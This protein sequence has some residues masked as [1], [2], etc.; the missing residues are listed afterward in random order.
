[1]KQLLQTINRFFEPVYTKKRYYIH[2]LF[3]VLARPFYGIIT[4]LFLAKAV[5][6]IQNPDKDAFFLIVGIYAIF[7]VLYQIYNY[8]G[9]NSGGWFIRESFKN[10]YPKYFSRFIKMDGNSFEKVGTGKMSSIITKGIDTRQ[11]LLM[12]T[13]YLGICAIVELLFVTYL[14][15]K[16]TRYSPLILY[17]F[18]IVIIII[19]AQLARKANSRREKR[20]DM[21]DELSRQ[22]TKIIMSKIDILLNNKINL[23]N[24]KYIN[25]LDEAKNYDTRKQVYEHIGFNVPT[26]CIALITV[27]LF[28]VLGYKFFFEQA[29]SYADIVLY[30]GLINSLENGTRDA[31][32]L[33]KTFSKNFQRVTKLWDIF[34]TIPEIK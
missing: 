31:I 23:E 34:D 30:L 17:I 9:K 13:G 33:Y 29:I 6:Y 21:V 27:S 11:D 12:Q 16:I 20:N 22:E 18:L 28:L 1:M 10:I 32:D 3:T 24:N 4:T 7:T 15:T 25:M 19:V 5:G 14:M 2:Y 26:L 8:F